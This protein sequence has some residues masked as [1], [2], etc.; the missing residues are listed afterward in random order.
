MAK[1]VKTNAARRLDQLGI[2]Y[3]V[4][5]YEVD[6]DDLSAE[7][8]AA[9]LGRPAE[10]LFKTL[11]ARGDRNGHCFAVLSGPDELDL[12]ALAAHTG[13]RRIELVALKDVRDLT[14]YVR[15]GVTVFGAKK[16]FP[17]YV[18]ARI[19][20]YAEISVSAGQR[21]LQLCLSPADYVRAA[22]AQL[23]PIARRPNNA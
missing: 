10:E 11:V 6:P 20:E 3:R 8:A 14:G 23:V 1:R 2:A 19:E 18:D 4:A 16:A 9:K 7:A 22:S 12:K 13:D 17:V 15:G 5:T 21:G